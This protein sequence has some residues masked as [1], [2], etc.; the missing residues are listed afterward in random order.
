MTSSMILYAYALYQPGFEPQQWHVF[1]CYLI[2]AWVCCFTVMF[3]QRALPLIIRTGGF[4][5]VAGLIVTVVVC[6][7]MPS[8]SGAGHASSHFVWKEW[9]NRTGYSSD[10]FTFLAGM[11]NGAFAIGA[12]DCVTHI[13]EEI[14]QYIT[15]IKLFPT[16]ANTVDRAAKNIPIALACQIIIGFATGFCYLISLSY[17]INDLPAIIDLNSLCPLGDIY[18]QATGS[19]AGAVGLLVVTLA[20]IFCA[21]IGCYITAGR[22]IYSLGRDD[23]T[24]F[25]KQIG[26][27]SPR[28]GSPLYATFACG[29]FITC[30]G[31]IYVGSTT[32]F[33]AFIGSF[34]LLTTVS[35]LLAILPHL[36]SGRKNIRPGSFWMGKYGP[37]VNVIAC[38]YIV[39]SFVIYCFPYALPTSPQSMNYTSVITC[40][41]TIFVVFWWLWRGRGSYMGPQ[42]ELYA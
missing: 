40:G 29:I 7:V 21:T 15:H 3:A 30:V 26:A 12:I 14:P 24:P 31:A 11:L 39:V 37:I 25:S 13:A 36:L 5:I 33:N 35:Y 41:V 10:G 17:A 6:S 4:L 22:T 28:F 1:I 19:K 20:P 38:L 42:M 2:I 18:L 34:V 8:R 9:S 32:A 23:A 27:V 16:V